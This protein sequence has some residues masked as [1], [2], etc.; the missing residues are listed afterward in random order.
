LVDFGQLHVS[1]GT[2]E[3]PFLF[4][5][6][7]SIQYEE[8]TTTYQLSIIFADI[9][10]N[11]L[12]NEKDCVSDM[13]LESKR[14]LSYLKRGIHT[15]PELYNNLDINFPV[16]AIPFFERFGDHVAGVAMDCN[17]IIFEDLNACDY[18]EILPTPT[19]TAGPSI[20]PSITPSQTATQTQTPTQTSTPT[21]TPTPTFTTFAFNVFGESSLNDLCLDPTGGLGITLWGLN[22]TFESNTILYLNS[23]LITF[24]PEGFYYQGGVFIQ[25]GLNGNVIGQVLC[26]S[27]TPTQ[28]PTETPTQTPTQT[29]SNTP[30]QTPTSTPTGTPT[31]TP[32]N[33]ETPTP[34][35]TPTGNITPEFCIGCGFEPG[36][37][38]VKVIGNNLYPFGVVE[39]YKLNDANKV[40][41]LNKVDAS[42]QSFLP[43]FGPDNISQVLDI[44]KTSASTYYFAGNFSTYDGVSQNRLVKTNTDLTRNTTF[45]NQNFQNDIYALYYDE[46]NNSLWVGGAFVGY[47]LDVANRYLIKI[48][49]NTAARDT[50]VPQNIANNPVGVIRPDG[51]GNLFIGGQFT[52][53]TG[54]ARN[55]LAKI[56]STDGTLVSGFQIGTGFNGTVFDMVHDAANNRLYVA[57]AFTQYSGVTSAAL[58]CLD[59]TTGFIDT[60]WS[61]SSFTAGQARSIVQNR[62]GDLFIYGSFGTYAGAAA[63]RLAKISSGGTMDLT[64]R[65]NIGT[66]TFNQTVNAFSTHSQ[67]AVDDN[68]L[69]LAGTF[70]A[71]NGIPTN[72][73]VRLDFDGNLLTSVMC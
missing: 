2:V 48:D 65:T 56:S 10:N 58:A 40:V 45:G 6:P 52:T 67:L 46:P 24:A 5:V 63:P 37:N 21:Q 68:Y 26:P 70:S 43:G 4:V 25:V 57:G 35:P 7:Q 8:N 69:Y 49:G 38:G 71:F 23:S 20:T 41:E 73:F 50:A 30:S 3:Y 28:T 61:G 9:L 47:N 22:P 39:Y 1:G 66:S 42:Q 33:T 31:N 18:Y 34:T 19:A 53:W 16:Q 36:L 11:D 55:R 51:A 60:T 54:T 72:G 13:S 59:A 32:T 29:P 17:L 64:F 15:F 27:Q 12:S 44:V 14:F 62:F